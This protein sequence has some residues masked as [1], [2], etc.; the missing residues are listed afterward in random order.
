MVWKRFRFLPALLGNLKHLANIP[1]DPP[2]NAGIDK[3]TGMELDEGRYVDSIFGG[4]VHPLCSSTNAAIETPGDG[5]Q[6]NHYY[7]GKLLLVSTGASHSKSLML[8][9][10][11][12]IILRRRLHVYANRCFQSPCGKNTRT[13]KISDLNRGSNMKGSSEFRGWRG[14]YQISKRWG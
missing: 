11:K 12:I 7:K 13:P 8:P 2:K 6:I 9:R 1:S 5:M 3:W 4:R 14:P 10:L